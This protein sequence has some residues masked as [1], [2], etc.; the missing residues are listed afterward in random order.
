MCFNT[1][2]Q[3]ASIVGDAAARQACETNVTTNSVRY[4]YDRPKAVCASDLC[5]TFRCN[6]V[7]SSCDVVTSVSC[8][9]NNICVDDVC[10]SSTGCMS[11]PKTLVGLCDDSNSCTADSCNA[12]AV[13]GAC[14]NT[15]LSTPECT[16]CTATSCPS[17]GDLCLP[18]TCHDN[19]A[20]PQVVNR[21]ACLV[22][23]A[24]VGFYCETLSIQEL[25]CA[26]K[27]DICTTYQC[28]AGVC[29]PNFRQCN[30]SS[31]CQVGVCSLAVGGCVYS[32]PCTNIVIAD[33]CREP[34]CVLGASFPNGY[35]CY[36]PSSQARNCSD[37]VCRATNVTARLL[38]GPA[39]DEFLVQYRTV[40]ARCEPRLCT[41]DTCDASIGCVNRAVSCMVNESGCNVTLGCFDIG[42]VQGFPPG[43]CQEQVVRSLIDF[44][45]VCKGDN[46]ACFFA[47]LNTGAVA[48]GVAGGVVAG[49]VIGAVIAALLAAYGAR[50]GYDY[51]QARS[52]LQSAAMHTNPYFNPN[53]LS[54]AMPTNGRGGGAD[55][56]R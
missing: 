52:D 9:S 56:G 46:V 36:D 17:T 24:A 1:A 42:N 34:T 47:T 27:N 50:K 12:S 49:I 2:A 25:R 22:Q 5:N 4:C 20:S 44:C 13:G 7:T 37:Y 48:G 30:V 54:G 21:T 39:A 35:S 28:V 41:V 31:A 40:N 45:G 19:C 18:T 43:V 26:P 10:V 33:K 29:V 3:C 23:K 14:V 6:P 38:V 53:E 55:T 11:V 16:S 51:Y 8:N 15:R 32:D